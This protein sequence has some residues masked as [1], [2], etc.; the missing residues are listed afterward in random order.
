MVWERKLTHFNPRVRAFDLCGV[1]MG[2]IGA[3]IKERY[4]LNCLI[5]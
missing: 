3:M 1:T 4:S 2:V 5:F